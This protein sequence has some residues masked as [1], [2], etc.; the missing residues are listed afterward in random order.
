MRSALRLPLA[1]SSKLSW[2]RSTA[3]A[4][5]IVDRIEQAERRAQKTGDDD[6]Y[7][8]DVGN[9]DRVLQYLPET[10]AETIVAKLRVSDFQ[11]WK[12]A[13]NELSEATRDR[14]NTCLR[15][16]LNLA[17]KNDPQHIRERTWRAAIRRATTSPMASATPF[18]A[19]GVSVS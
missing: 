6:Q 3:T 4:A 11:E 19:N 1:T 18:E 12:D 10:L 5:E 16:A 9:A 14:I 7:G 13:F 8:G 2:K 15:A 17:A